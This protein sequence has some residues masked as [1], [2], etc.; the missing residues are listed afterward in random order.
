MKSP[1][2]PVVFTLALLGLGCQ[3][4]VSSTG[5]GQ[6]VTSA[7]QASGTTAGKPS[8]PAQ[9]GSPTAAQTPTPPL[10]EDLKTS[11]YH[12]YGLS[13][14]QTV[15]I[16]LTN[17]GQSFT[18]KQ[19]VHLKSVKGGV[20]TFEIERTGDIADKLGTDTISL[21]KGGIYTVGSTMINGVTRNLEMPADVKPGA[22]WQN[23]G[24][25]SMTQGE[26]VQDLTI[27]A[28]EER[29][30]ATVR[31]SE[32][33]LVVHQSGTMTVNGAKYRIV[34]DY[35]YVQD[36]GVVKSVATMTNASDP[37]AKPVS[38]TIQETKP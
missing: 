10:P 37:K 12:W 24:K 26:V 36:K 34:S 19:T 3:S 9:S 11:A 38:I 1:Y 13:N 32:T 25:V 29:K 28:V 7:A 2:G 17:G 30:V 6:S 14:D 15:S 31:G 33:A 16:K 35:W 27:K 18:G 20:A 4:P 21:E 22:T 5:S 8:D 23:T